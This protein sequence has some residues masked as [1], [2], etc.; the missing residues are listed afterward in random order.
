MKRRLL[1]VLTAV[2]LLLCVVLCVLW[3]RSHRVGSVFGYYT[4]ADRNGWY[5]CIYFTSH[6]GRLTF[7]FLNTKFR[8]GWSHG[9][10]QARDTPNN[11]IQA[12]KT[13]AGFYH[14][15]TRGQEMGWTEVGVPYWFGVLTTAI[16]PVFGV[17][18]RLRQRHDRKAGLCRTCGY[19]LRA[20]PERCPECGK[21]STAGLPPPIETVP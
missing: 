2:S 20:T 21:A 8:E 16:A 13:F 11:Q 5:R 19:D 18:L 7:V 12:R 15:R 6:T 17:L 4:N 9:R 1:N 10:F 3:V 14:F